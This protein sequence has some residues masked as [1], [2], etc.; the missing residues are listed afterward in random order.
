VTPEQIQRLDRRTWQLFNGFLDG[1]YQNLH[2]RFGRYMAAALTDALGNEDEQIAQAFARIEREEPELLRA[3]ELIRVRARSLAVVLE[4]G[5]WPDGARS[6][7]TQ[8]GA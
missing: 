4:G 6:D 8:E 2:A 1:P 5:A 7:A 3:C